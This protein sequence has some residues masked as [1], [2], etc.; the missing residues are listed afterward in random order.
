MEKFLGK[1]AFGELLNE[2]VTKPTGTPTLA[3]ITDRRPEIHS[4][5]AAQRDFAALK[6]EQV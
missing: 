1:K 6:Q 5:A 4:A 2:M 3:P